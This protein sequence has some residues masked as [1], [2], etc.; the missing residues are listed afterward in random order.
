MFSSSKYFSPK[1]LKIL[2]LPVWKLVSFT[3]NTNNLR[4]MHYSKLSVPQLS[5]PYSA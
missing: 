3:L 1:I 4:I 5:C 2:L